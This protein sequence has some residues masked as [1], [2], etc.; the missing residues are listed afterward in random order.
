MRCTSR[1]AGCFQGNL[2]FVRR[3]DRISEFFGHHCI[4]FYQCYDHFLQKSGIRFKRLDK[5]L[6]E[7]RTTIKT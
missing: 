7:T 1:S 3:S 6:I 5:R 2:K 4:G